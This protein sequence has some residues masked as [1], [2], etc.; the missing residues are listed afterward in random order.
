MDTKKKEESHESQILKEQWIK[1][2]F[3][4]CCS[5]KHI[6]LICIESLSVL[7]EYNLKYHYKTNMKVSMTA[8]QVI[9]EMIKATQ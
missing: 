6:C 4:I 3:F 7:K 2:Y 8:L 9:Q 1:D 5:N